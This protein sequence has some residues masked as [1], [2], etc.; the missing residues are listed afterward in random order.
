MWEMAEQIPGL[1]EDRTPPKEGFE[2]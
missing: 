1:F 2:E